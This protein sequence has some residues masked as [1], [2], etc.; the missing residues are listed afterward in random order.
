MRPVTR[1]WVLKARVELSGAYPAGAGV[2]GPRTGVL[3][4]FV[5]ARGTSHWAFFQPQKKHWGVFTVLD[6][7]RKHQ[8]RRRSHAC[9]LS[10]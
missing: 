4:F 1:V 9:L 8:L 2:R 5:H 3:D 7:T 10:V 6:D